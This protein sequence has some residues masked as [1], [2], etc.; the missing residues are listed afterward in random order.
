MTKLTLVSNSKVRENLR[1]FDRFLRRGGL[2]IIFREEND[3]AQTITLTISSQSEAEMRWVSLVAYQCF[4]G[5][6]V[7]TQL[8]DYLSINKPQ[9]SNNH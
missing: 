9:L 4:M 3:Q 6:V 2:T 8:A 1:I 5:G 7:G